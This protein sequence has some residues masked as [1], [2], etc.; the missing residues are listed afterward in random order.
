M[1]RVGTRGASVVDT[2]VTMMIDYLV[3]DDWPVDEPAW[4]KSL[5]SSLDRQH[6]KL[7]VLPLSVATQE[8]IDWVE[9]ASDEGAW[10]SR[11]NRRSL[12]ADLNQSARALG[13]RTAARLKGPL[14][15]LDSALAKLDQEA[16]PVLREIMGMR[17]SPEWSRVR[18]AASVL[19][20]ELG[21]D[22]TVAAS[23]GDLVGCARKA[24]QE[25]REY[26]AIADLLM[27]QIRFRGHDPEALRREVVDM[28][29]YGRSPGDDPRVDRVVPP[30]ERAQSAEDILRAHPEIGHVVVWLGYR[31]CRVGVVEAGNITFLDAAWAVPNADPDDTNAPHTDFPHKEEL[32]EI[33]QWGLFKV[34]KLADDESEVETI[35][36]V[37]LGRTGMAGA[38]ERA[39]AM[40]DTILSAALHRSSGTRPLLT[41]SVV[42]FDGAVRQSVLGAGGPLT[43]KDDYFGIGLTRD[44]IETL[45]PDLGPAL[46]GGELPRLLAAAIEAQTGADAPFSR[47]MLGQPPSAADLRSVIPLEDRVVRCVAAF[48]GLRCD[49]VFAAGAALWPHSRWFSDVDRAIRMCLLGSGPNSTD[50][51]ILQR[52]YYSAKSQGAWARFV[53]SSE[54]ELIRV[55]RIESDRRWIERMLRSVAVPAVYSDIIAEHQGEAAILAD[56]RKRVR[57]AIVH[58]NPVGAQVVQSV[59]GFATFVSRYALQAG[60]AS[61]VSGV[62]LAQLLD[63][64]HRTHIR[65][66]DGAS[67]VDHWAD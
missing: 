7:S 25:R 6:G 40:V 4:T 28:L 60:L 3:R 56:R 46:A 1:W 66:L 59:S 21:S 8:L 50:V 23:W 55:C 57:N 37:D 34:A 13:P 20:S 12:L 24:D 15:T 36:R 32:A 44:A 38:R 53:N 41:Q 51:A 14:S 62:S 48:A 35:V 42:L 27:D 65:L 49:D 33:V 22:T 45:V 64:D 61:F 39:H 10:S 18:V 67:I 58:A 54:A 30:E 43:L 63:T 26:R 19:L 47:E 9:L 29:A 52:G 31:Q 16:K 11:E 5:V 2:I 17:T